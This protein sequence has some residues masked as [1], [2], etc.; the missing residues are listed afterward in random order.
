L[1]LFF[2]SNYL[3]F[4]VLKNF[5][6]YYLSIYFIILFIMA[7]LLA[8]GGP[9]ST[10]IKIGKQILMLLS[11]SRSSIITHNKMFIIWSYCNMSCLTCM[12]CST[13]QTLIYVLSLE[14]NVYSIYHTL[15]ADNSLEEK[16]SHFYASRFL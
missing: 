12:E 16:M 8:K 9:Y 6:I 2:T 10:Q 11:C 1:N 5:T 7:F 13:F 3:K 14:G 15:P 4:K